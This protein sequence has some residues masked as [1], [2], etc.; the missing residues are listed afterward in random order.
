MEAET[1]RTRT[2][3]FDGKIEMSPSPSALSRGRVAEEKQSLIG[4]SDSKRSTNTGPPVGTPRSPQTVVLST[5]A[6]PAGGDGGSMPPPTIAARRKET[7]RSLVMLIFGLL[8]LFTGL[9]LAVSRLPS[10]SSDDSGVPGG[11]ATSG[12]VAPL[13][14]PVPG[15]S[16]WWFAL[17]DT[18]TNQTFTTFVHLG[19]G[20]QRTVVMD[21]EA[22]APIY[23]EQVRQDAV[24]VFPSG[25]HSGATCISRP[26]NPER[27]LD[28]VQVAC[29][30]LPIAAG[31]FA[32]L[33]PALPL[34]NLSEHMFDLP[35]DCLESEWACA[36][37]TGLPSGTFA[38]GLRSGQD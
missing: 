17:L 19:R 27:D 25:D 9:L 11:D 20:V 14:S 1:N 32:V 28:W 6:G 35:R 23:E 31:K 36:F 18:T 21:A 13:C 37:A 5:F 16:I 22:T 15:A 10:F 38:T 29:Q 24:I 26:R 7:Q 4:S 2:T 12:F 3:T 34:P 33:Q 8:L 30:H